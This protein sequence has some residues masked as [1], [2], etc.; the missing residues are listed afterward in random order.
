MYQ[1]MCAAEGGGCVPTKDGGPKKIYLVVWGDLTT[2][3]VCAECIRENPKLF[4][5]GVNIHDTGRVV[6]HE[7]FPPAKDEED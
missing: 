6:N 7:F 3:F 1:C 4:K 5:D 2:D